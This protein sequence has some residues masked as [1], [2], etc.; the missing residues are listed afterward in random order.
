VFVP[1]GPEEAVV[2]TFSLDPSPPHACREEPGVLVLLQRV[3]PIVDLA[4]FPP[5][6][7]VR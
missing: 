2:L 1:D 3:I 6:F 5:P 7:T 4:S